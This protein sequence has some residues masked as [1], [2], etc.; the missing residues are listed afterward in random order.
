MSKIAMF[1]L[2]A[3]LALLLGASVVLA[4]DAVSPGPGRM[5]QG[6]ANTEQMQQMHEAMGEVPEAMQQMHDAMS[7]AMQSGD[8]QQMQDAM[9]QAMQN[10]GMQQM[11]DAMGQN[12][13]EGMQ[14]MHDAMGEAMQSGDVQQMQDTCQGY[15][16]GQQPE[17]TE[18]PA[19]GTPPT[20]NTGG[21]GGMMRNI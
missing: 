9:N 8:V 2:I 19:P 10:G 3:I 7:Q 5:M 4:Q 14:Q 12:V 13:P 17:G 11:H 15:M 20:S 18:T 1:G 21:R 16:N 6:P